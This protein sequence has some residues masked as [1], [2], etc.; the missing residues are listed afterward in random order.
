MITD[1]LNELSVPRPA[2]ELADTSLPNAHKLAHELGHLPFTNVMQAYAEL[3]KYLYTFNRIEIP[4]RQWQELASGFVYS[5]NE[6]M[7]IFRDGYRNVALPLAGRNLEK[8]DAAQSL[9]A[10]MAFAFKLLIKRYVA[11]HAELQGEAVDAGLVAGFYN[12]LRYLSWQ[13]LDSY[14]VYEVP[15]EGLWREMNLIYRVCETLDVQERIVNNE[16]SPAMLYKQIA[17]VALLD[18]YKLMRGEAVMLFDKARKWHTAMRVQCPDADERVDLSGR[19]C[20]DLA[21]AGAPGFAVAQRRLDFADARIIELAALTDALEWAARGADE[22]GVSLN[23]KRDGAAQGEF[24]KRIERNFLARVAKGVSRARGRAFERADSDATV[25]AAIGLS[26]CH[27]FV[28]GGAEFLPEVD[29]VRLHREGRDEGDSAGGLELTLMPED[30]EPWKVDKQIDDLKTGVAN[31]RATHFS[32]DQNEK[33]IWQSIYASEG[34]SKLQ[35]VMRFEALEWTVLDEGE[36]GMALSHTRDALVRAAVGD[37]MAYHKEQ[38]DWRYAMIR[39]LRVDSDGVCEIGVMN[40]AEQACPVACR[41]VGGPGGGTEYFRALLMPDCQLR[42]Q[43]TTIIVPAAIYDI[44][45]V[46]ALNFG[47]RIVYA[48]L[49]ELLE[50]TRLFSQFRC[51]PSEVPADELQKIAELRRH[52]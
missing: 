32:A 31:P 13:I 29:E 44:D 24:R 10:E 34:R 38:A 1:L 43:G 5:A 2:P 52:A 15:R 4:L 30:Y 40:L 39:R 21:G 27:H 26:A 49:R 14:S 8:F 37:L 9:S 11:A 47:E 50:T 45:T 33:N 17:L 46:L 20:V 25:T 18:P 41:A 19:F 28:S 16:A 48:Q 7:S 23:L 42:E 36:G 22:S 35:H 6:L 12:V 51:L 3:H